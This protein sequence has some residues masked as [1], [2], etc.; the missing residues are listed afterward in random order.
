MVQCILTTLTSLLKYKDHRTYL[1]R[2]LEKS[3]H[4][5]YWFYWKCYENVLNG[6]PHSPIQRKKTNFKIIP[7]VTFH[8]PRKKYI[9]P[10][11]YHLKP[12]WRLWLIEY[13]K[14]NKRQSKSIWRMLKNEISKIKIELNVTKCNHMRCTTCFYN[15]QRHN[16]NFVGKEFTIKNNICLTRGPCY[17]IS[18]VL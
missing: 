9:A 14:N 3:W 2:K 7:L 13:I 10:S 4:D 11:F 17:H 5:Y 16:F 18:R 6:H 12:F 15:R 8:Y 1:L